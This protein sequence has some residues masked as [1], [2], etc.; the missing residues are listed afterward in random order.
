[1]TREQEAK[2]REHLHEIKELQKLALLTHVGL[3][4][5]PDCDLSALTRQSTEL[6]GVIY[7][8]DMKLFQIFG[9]VHKIRDSQYPSQTPPPAVTHTAKDLLELLT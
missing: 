7:Q 9:I 4:E 5:G 8:L 1:M 2:L 6:R 3:P